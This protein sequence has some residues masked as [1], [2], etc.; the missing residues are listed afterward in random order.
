MYSDFLVKN[1]RYYHIFYNKKLKVRHVSYSDALN[2][3]VKFTYEIF[4]QN[5][6][7]S[8]RA[9]LVYILLSL[10]PVVILCII[11]GSV[12]LARHAEEMLPLSKV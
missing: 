12:D 5:N 3:V 6:R 8:D 4:I 2:F 10:V 1:Y 11:S 7:L 9:L